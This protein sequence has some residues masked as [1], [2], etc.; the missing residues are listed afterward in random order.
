VP[1]GAQLRERQ[2]GIALLPPSAV[3]LQMLNLLAP[4]QIAKLPPSWIYAGH[5]MSMNFEA[6]QVRGQMRK[7]TAEGMVLAVLADATSWPLRY[8]DKL[9]L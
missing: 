4:L 3:L 2:T 8:K 1:P 9:N 5:L 6:E 7:F